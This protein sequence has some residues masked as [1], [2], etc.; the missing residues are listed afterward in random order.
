M[1]LLPFPLFSEAFEDVMISP[2]AVGRGNSFTGIAN[3]AAAIIYNPAGLANI[4]SYNVD[5]Y[6]CNLYNM[7]LIDYYHLS[8]VVPGLWKGSFGFCWNHQS[9][10]ESLPI[11]EFKEEKFYLSYG[12]PV[13]SVLLV[14]CSLKYYFAKYEFNK[15]AVFSSDIS[16]LLKISKKLQAGIIFKDFYSP[17]YI[18][19]TE[20]KEILDNKIRIG[21]AL[22][23]FKNLNISYDCEDLLENHKKQNDFIG[24]EFITFNNRL[25][26]KTGLMNLYLHKYTPTGGFVYEF[27]YFDFK[28]SFSNHYDLDWSH[29]FGITFK[30]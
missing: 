13:H 5:F 15:T 2:D 19:Y 28:Y 18:W 30:F 14:G 29:I 4:L 10:D 23:L 6:Y 17:S 11:K 24:L 27:E 16:F 26:L 22:F 20:E 1:I 21:F 25:S 9:L 8:F 7:D 12:V 3:K